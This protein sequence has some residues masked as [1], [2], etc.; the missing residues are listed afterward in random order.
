MSEDFL[1]L[2]HIRP[3]I[4]ILR[5]SFLIIRLHLGK[6]RSYFVVQRLHDENLVFQLV[7][8]IVFTNGILRIEVRR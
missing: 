6:I 4:G 1:D 5:I 8:H 2:V 7:I 3:H